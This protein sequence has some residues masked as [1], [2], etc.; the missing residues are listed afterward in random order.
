MDDLCT[1]EQL[2]L[3][4]SNIPCKTAQLS[5]IFLSCLDCHN[6]YN[7]QITTINYSETSYNRHSD[8]QTTSLQQKI[9]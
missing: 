5:L 8:K 1:F 7:Q 2:S 6:L 4:L 9:A 3:H